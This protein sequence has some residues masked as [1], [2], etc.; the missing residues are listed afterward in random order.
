VDVGPASSKPLVNVTDRLEHASA[1]DRAADALE[2]IVASTVAKGEAG[3]LLS[4]GWLGHALH[5]MLTDVPIGAWTSALILDV[6]GGS[7]SEHAADLL[8]T[9]GLAAVAPTA[10]SGW[11][12]W[13]AVTAPEQRRVGLVHAAA[14]I[15]AA[16]IFGTS[17]LRRREGRR[18]AGKLL[19]FAG[20]AAV[21]AGGYLGGHLSYA[22][23]VGVGE[24]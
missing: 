16:A 10:L 5:P 9:V 2:P 21:A 24:R 20:A 18:G 1:L 13:G 8:M 12:D 7:S 15:T 11:S 22:R 23:S 14:N 17:L 3:Y 4:G 6:F 19:G